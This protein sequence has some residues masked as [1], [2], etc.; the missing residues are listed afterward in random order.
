MTY[1]NHNKILVL[2]KYFTNDIEK[3]IK[4]NNMR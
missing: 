3:K 2:C 4:N 1:P